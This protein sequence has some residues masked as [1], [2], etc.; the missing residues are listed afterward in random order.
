MTERKRKLGIT[1][2]PTSASAPPF[3]NPRREATLRRGRSRPCMSHPQSLV[4]SKLRLLF[5]I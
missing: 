3:I 2:V 5:I 1:E 4:S